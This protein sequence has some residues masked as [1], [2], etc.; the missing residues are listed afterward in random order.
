ATAAGLQPRLGGGSLPIAESDLPGHQIERIGEHAGLEGEIGGEGGNQLVAQ[1]RGGGGEDFGR[2]GL[3]VHGQA[4]GASRRRRS[5]SA[6][7]T[8]RAII[9]RSTVPSVPLRNSLTLRAQTT[10]Q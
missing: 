2:A 3:V 4:L 10:P 1:Q 6:S 5:S 7:D 8:R 9:A